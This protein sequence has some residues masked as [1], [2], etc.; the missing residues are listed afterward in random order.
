[1]LPRNNRSQ[2][3]APIFLFP[4]ST[5]YR[6]PEILPHGVKQGVFPITSLRGTVSM[7]YIFFYLEADTLESLVRGIFVIK[8]L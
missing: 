8:L 4:L 3:S 5:E 6:G 7:L 1:M 2:I